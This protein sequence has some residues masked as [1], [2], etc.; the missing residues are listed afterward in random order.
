MGLFG[1]ADL[2]RARFYDDLATTV[3]AGLPV[4]D[5]LRNVGGDAVDGLFGAARAMEESI[6]AGGD[7]RDAM[8]ERGGLFTPFE[9]HVVAAGEK[10]GRLVESMK[11][12]ARHFERRGAM[13]DA[14]GYG[15][16]YPAFLVHFA[17]LVLPV[18]HLFTGDAAGYA[19][20]ALVP[21]L[22]LYALVAGAWLLFSSAARNPALRARLDALVLAVPVLGGAAHRAAMLELVSTLGALTSAGLPIIE[23]LDA[24]ADAT[25]NSVVAGAARRARDRIRD[26]ATL[27]EAFA[28]ERDVAGGLF[29]DAVR[30]GEASGKLDE[31]FERLERTLGE[32]LDRRLRSIAAATPVIAYLGVVAFLAYTIVSMF[33]QVYIRPLQDAMNGR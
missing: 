5:A 10:G 19:R 30:V 12:L 15:F 9:R 11:R 16:I 23:T 32:E 6:R 7:L 4:R 18:R 2:S 17:F 3:D 29:V 27:A 20:A 25:R 22:G 24:S 33:M 26:G 14:L 13:R 8:E 21:L 31:T 28:P 1:A